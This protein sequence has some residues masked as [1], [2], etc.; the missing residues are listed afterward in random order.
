MLTANPWG[1]TILSIELKEVL[2]EKLLEK[3]DKVIVEGTATSEYH[4][5]EE[6]EEKG[7]VRVQGDKITLF[8]ENQNLKRV[9]IESE[10][11]SSTGRFLPVGV[12]EGNPRKW[13]EWLQIK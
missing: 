10:P 9:I 11:G 4:V 8:V 7:T 6:G 2:E 13:F 3:V 1:V 12:A 5:I